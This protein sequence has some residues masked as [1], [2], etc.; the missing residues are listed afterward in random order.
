VNL[1]IG[2]FYGNREYSMSMHLSAGNASRIL[3]ACSRTHAYFT[4][5]DKTRF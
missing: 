5:R 1:E 3:H 2:S 4:R